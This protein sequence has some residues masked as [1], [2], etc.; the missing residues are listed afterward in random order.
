M[1]AH[2]AALIRYRVRGVDW[3]TPYER[4]RPFNSRL[5]CF[6]EKYKYKDGLE[7]ERYYVH[8]GYRG[9]FFG[10]YAMTGQ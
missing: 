9:I 6:A 3:K 8:R 5:V 2:C 4:M 1:A 10:M 7:E